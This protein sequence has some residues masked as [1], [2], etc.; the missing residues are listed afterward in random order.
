MI[1]GVGVIGSVSALH[2]D[3]N[4]AYESNKAARK[5][6]S[7][8]GGSKGRQVDRERTEANAIRFVM[9][10]VVSITR[11]EPNGDTWP[12]VSIGMLAMA[13]VKI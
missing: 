11:F 6:G 4:H 9:S 8:V 3:F 5:A 2:L 12:E 10:P 7:Q 13:N 1:G